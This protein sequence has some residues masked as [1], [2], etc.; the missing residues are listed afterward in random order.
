MATTKNSSHTSNRKFRYKTRSFV[1]FCCFFFL[2]FFFFT[3]SLLPSSGTSYGLRGSNDIRTRKRIQTN[4]TDANQ[5]KISTKTNSQPKTR[6]WSWNRN[7][8]KSIQQW[9]TKHCCQKITLQQDGCQS[10]HNWPDIVKRFGN[11]IVAK[12]KNTTN[13]KK[14]TFSRC[15]CTNHVNEPSSIYHERTQCY[16]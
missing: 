3:Q 4:D 2:F 5:I 10:I 8:V 15:F 7:G 12:K 6:R 16:H 9:G 13:K 11:D 14:I 1:F